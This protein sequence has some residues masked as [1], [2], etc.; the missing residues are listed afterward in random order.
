MST[1]AGLA[2]APVGGLSAR[3]AFWFAAAVTALIFVSGVFAPY[4]SVDSWSYLELSNRVFT[5]FFRLNTLRRFE[6]PSPYSQAFPPLLPVLI[7]VVRKFANVGIYA[8]TLLNFPICI[9][10]LAAAIRLVQK[11]SFPGWIGA[12][13]YLML[14]GFPAFRYEATGGKS[15]PL[16]LTLL[17]CALLVLLDERIR[18]R[19]VAL[20]GLSMGAACLD[21]FDAMAA[22]CF[23]GAAFAVLAYRA[24]ERPRG[25]IRILAVY[26]AVLGATISPMIAYG[27]RH[28]GKPFPSDNTSM[29]LLAKGGSSLDYYKTPAQPDLFRNPEKWL[30]GLVRPKLSTL[31]RG[32]YESAA[33]TML[34]FL[35]A[36]VLVVWGAARNQPIAPRAGPFAAVALC[37]IPVM[38][39]PDLLAG[40]RESRYYSGSLLLL[41]LLSFLTLV[42]L[43]PE[44]WNARRASL[45]VLIAALPLGQA[46]LQPLAASRGNLGSLRRMMAPRS[47]TAEMRQVTDA[48]NRDSAGQPHRLVFTSGHVTAV[49]YGAL[50]GEPAA[51]MPRLMS[52]T[53]ADFARD[54]GI[55][56]VYD[57]PMPRAPWEGEPQSSRAD[58]MRTIQGP[59][60]ELVPLD[61]PGLYRIRLTSAGL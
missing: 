41:F 8:G 30:A 39:I 29:V 25:V 12:S 50:T 28:F 9:G 27:M 38:L 43:T 23:I 3:R 60:V 20:A 13:S 40:F 34:P 17:L 31:V 46:A 11:L 26:F 57:G 2:P 6:T 24:G 32:F 15:I 56:H 42:S 19:R 53:F 5:D 7:A 47:P 55:T 48:V 45:V 16:Y 59:G 52:G 36:I 37:L 1:T 10:L 61:L 21:R 33:E 18:P 35:L 51:V 14:L 49:K 22:A 4:F 58:E 44:A 54:W